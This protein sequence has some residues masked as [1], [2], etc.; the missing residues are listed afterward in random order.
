MTLARLAPSDEPTPG[1]PSRLHAQ[2]VRHRDPRRGLGGLCDRLAHDG[3]RATRD[4][5]LVEAGPDHGAERTSPDD[6][7]D[8]TRNSTARTT[9]AT[10]TARERRSALA[11]PM[12]RGRVVGRLSAVNTCI[13][14]RGVPADYDEWA[15]RGP[16]RR[17]RGPVPARVQAAGARPRPRQRR[18]AV[19]AL[20]GERARARRPAARSVAARRRSSCRLA[21]RASVEAAR[22]LGFAAVRDHNATG[23]L[24]GVG[25]HAM[26]RRS[27]A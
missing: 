4:V 21:A 13:A 18:R 25:P 14:L 15:A 2:R 26:Q 3:A 11:F 1:L 7:R 20:R 9:G 27:T 16:A 17:G 10:P 19:M 5:L 12:P 8:G 23:A 6:L 22:A 24:E